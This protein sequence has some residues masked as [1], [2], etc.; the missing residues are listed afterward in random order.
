M[1][2]ILI[3]IAVIIIIGGW[4]HYENK[5]T[6]LEQAEELAYKYAYKEG[7]ERAFFNCAT[8]NQRGLYDIFVNTSHLADSMK[9]TFIDVNWQKYNEGIRLQKK[10]FEEKKAECYQQLDIQY[11][12][13]KYGK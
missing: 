3:I 13:N 4:I 2:I 5:I 10:S 9:K 1:N 6:Q 11:L 12:K 8:M 7:S